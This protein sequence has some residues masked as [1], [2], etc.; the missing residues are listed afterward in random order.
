MR[1]AA[2]CALNKDTLLVQFQVVCLC[3]CEA[4]LVSSRLS[5]QRAV[6]L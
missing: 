2:G 3:A 1:I 4:R 6:V 5:S